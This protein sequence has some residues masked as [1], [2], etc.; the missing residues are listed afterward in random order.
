MIDTARGMSGLRVW[1]MIDLVS[2]TYNNYAQT[3]EGILPTHYPLDD[4]QRPQLITFGLMA[5]ALTDIM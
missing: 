3:G 1:M 4:R 2:G 5:W